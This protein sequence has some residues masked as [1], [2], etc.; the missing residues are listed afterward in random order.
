MYTTIH[1]LCLFLCEFITFISMTKKN[2]KYKPNTGDQEL[3]SAL[4][5]FRRSMDDLGKVTKEGEEE[6]ARKEKLAKEN[7]WKKWVKYAII[8]IIIVL[9][10]QLGALMTP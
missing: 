9:L 5:R 4:Y 7:E 1:K 6:R 8:F 10:V 3:D 2:K